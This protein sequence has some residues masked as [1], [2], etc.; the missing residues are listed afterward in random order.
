[1]VIDKSQPG[2]RGLA[3]RRVVW[4]WS[5]RHSKRRYSRVTTAAS[6][7]S[8]TPVVPLLLLLLLL[9]PA[10][11][12]PPS[13][14][15][16]PGAPKARPRAAPR[17]RLRW[18]RAEFP[19]ASA[20][21]GGRRTAIWESS[22]WWAALVVTVVGGLKEFG[23]CAAM[24]ADPAGSAAWLSEATFFSDCWISNKTAAAAAAG[25][26]PR[27][28]CC[29]CC[30]I[31]ACSCCRVRSRRRSA[32]RCVE[33]LVLWLWLA[34]K[35]CCRCPRRSAACVGNQRQIATQHHLVQVPRQALHEDARG[36]IRT[37]QQSK[38]ER[39]SRATGRACLLD[40]RREESTSRFAAITGPSLTLPFVQG[41]RYK[42]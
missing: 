35:C 29:C 41:S 28:I 2:Q 37:S 11:A 7:N 6:S 31:S 1:M 34:P 8:P 18:F 24:E 30:R 22:S 38:I 13:S 42:R 25:L 16:P 14:K 19:G 5:Q 40:E 36:S 10:A 9:L 12:V 33:V 21:A 27:L 20:G 39:R 3:P 15:A 32:R 17:Q 4:V 26:V 23:S